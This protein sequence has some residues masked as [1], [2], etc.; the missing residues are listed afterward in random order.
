[1]PY[2]QGRRMFHFSFC[3]LHA[4]P[5]P[6]SH[7]IIIFSTFAARLKHD[8]IMKKLAFILLPVLIILFACQSK[9]GP[10]K[11]PEAAGEKKPDQTLVVE[12]DKTV[13]GNTIKDVKPPSK[14]TKEASTLFHRGLELV[15]SGKYPEGIDYL[16]RAL[17]E[18]PKNARI[19]FNRGNAYYMTK[20]YDKALADFNNSLMINPSDTM[21]ILYSGLTK[22][23]KNDFPGAFQ[24]FSNAIMKSKH[25]SQAY[26]NRGL[27]RGQL[28]DYKGAVDDFTQSIIIDPT[29]GN[30]YYNRGLA[31]FYKKDT[32]NAC[33]DWIQANRMGVPGAQKAVD[34]YCE[35]WKR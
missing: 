24:D 5:L 31:N 17:A 18:D 32:M 19:L 14:E 26:Y 27:V 13:T 8:H 7:A 20:E 1:M 25:F 6:C 22:Y 12:P 3:I 16:T 29:Y 33:F 21:V 34:E 23:F 11:T 35:K 9:Q 15:Q 10:S 28:K 30:A 2:G 4:S